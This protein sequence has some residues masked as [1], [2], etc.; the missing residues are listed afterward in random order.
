MRLFAGIALLCVI[1]VSAIAQ[2]SS[3]Q[4]QSENRLEHAKRI[5]SVT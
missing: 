5:G 3:P 1:A 2:S 4:A